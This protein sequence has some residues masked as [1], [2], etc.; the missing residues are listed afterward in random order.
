MQISKNLEDNIKKLKQELVSDDITF[1]DV[2]IHQTNG[3]LV[4]INDLVNK[5]TL[6][7][8]ILRPISFCKEKSIVFKKYIYKC[9][10]V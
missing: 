6:G 10:F 9:F 4:F 5:D 3:I 8:L 7:E 1:L 2:K